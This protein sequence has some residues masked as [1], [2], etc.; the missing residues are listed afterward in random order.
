MWRFRAQEAGAR[1]TFIF[2]RERQRRF[3]KCNYF[4]KISK[5][6]LIALFSSVMLLLVGCATPREPQRELTILTYNIHHGEGTDGKI[7][8]RR[9]ANVIKRSQADV[10][11]LQEVD[12]NARR[13]GGVDQAAELGRLAGMHAAYGPAM[14]FQG[15]EYGQ[16]ILSR[17]PIL[18]STVHAL[19]QRTNREPRI[20]FATQVADDIWFVSTHLD[21][22]IEEIRVSQ[23][24]ALVKLFGGRKVILAGDFNAS[25]T[26]QTMR[27]F[28]NWLDTGSALGQPTFPAD[29]PRSRIDYI[30]LQPKSAWRVIDCQVLDESLAS[31]HRP[32]RARVVW[33][34]SARL[35]FGQNPRAK[36][37]AIR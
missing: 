2:D 33:S 8:L 30:F 37:P 14:P 35:R 18:A 26:N 25:P 15:G 27:L 36:S 1:V 13:S 6:R 11:A 12:R 29:H 9:I 34:G 17:H 19:P 23:A 20:A 16:A 5:M 28:S 3:A 21:H 7:D 24:Q 22:E 31:D 4:P 10:V 32:V